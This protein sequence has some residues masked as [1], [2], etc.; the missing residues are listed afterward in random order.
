[1]K[2]KID[3]FPKTCLLIYFVAKWSQG[4]AFVWTPLHVTPLA[5]IFN[6]EEQNK[7][8]DKSIYLSTINYLKNIYH[9]FKKI[10]T[11]A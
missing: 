1:M 11:V 7:E 5:T 3:Y 2:K 10:T 9:I 8:S 6:R 4:R